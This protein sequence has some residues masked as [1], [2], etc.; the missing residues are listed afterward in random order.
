MEKIT[1]RWCGMENIS[2]LIITDDKAY[3]KALGTGIITVCRNFDI[4]IMNSYDFF[5]ERKEFYFKDVDGV[6]LD[7]YDLIL[8]DGKEASVSFGDKIILMTDDHAMVTRNYNDKRFCVYKYS[9]VRVMVSVLLDIYSFLTGKCAVNLQQRDVQ[10]ISFV[11]AEGGAG[12]TTLAMAAAQELSRFRGKKVMYVSFEEIESTGEYMECPSGIKGVGVY[13]Y[14]LFKNSNGKPFIESYVVHDGFGT[15]AFAPTKGRN[16]LRSLTCDE[17]SIF[18]S[19]LIECGR[20][21]VILMDTGNNLCE[22]DILCA[23]VASKICFVTSQSVK[24][25]RE[26]QYLQYLMC[27]CGEQIVSK[28]IKVR[29]L[30]SPNEGTSLYDKKDDILEPCLYIK[31]YNGIVY[32][33]NITKIIVENGFGENIRK[34]VEKLMERSSEL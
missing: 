22:M 2:L 21:D 23:D 6:F 34:L 19:S 13:L 15:E 25:I 26:V 31:R 29:N 16:P 17:L 12:T 18:L 4:K 14:H 33:E 1:K 7:K 10:I 24:N 5:S 27:R 11:S 3:G 8:W 32:N 30:I 9:N 28:I 20:Y